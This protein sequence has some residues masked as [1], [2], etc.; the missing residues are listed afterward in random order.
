MGFLPCK[1][2]PKWDAP[3]GM[4]R[5]IDPIYDI[6]IRTQAEFDALIA[7]GT[8]F[9]AVSVAIIG[10]FTLSASNNSGVK[11]PATVKQIH[12]FNGAKITITNFL[13][14]DST[15]AR[16]GLW[17]D[18]LPATDDYEVRGLTI[19]C[20]AVPSAGIYGIAGVGIANIR[21]FFGT[22]IGRGGVGSDVGYGGNWGVGAHNCKNIRGT[23]K[24][25]GGNGFDRVS[26]GTGGQAGDGYGVYNCNDVYGDVYA[27]GG[28]GGNGFGNIANN[29]G[30]EGGDGTAVYGGEKYMVT[31]YAYKGV[32]GTGYITEQDGIAGIAYGYVNSSFFSNCK[33]GALDSGGTLWVGTNP[34]RDDDSC[35]LT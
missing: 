18:T 26:N 9:G 14:S 19:D 5:I 21:N 16:G 31:I 30:G 25:Y 17:Y 24:G 4:S 23:F 33:K 6:V 3:D 34:K 15:P 1:T 29:F 7:D 10:A 28:R 20:T 12:G 13:Y 32:G 2:R 22:T 35:D 27:Y 8:W 11:I